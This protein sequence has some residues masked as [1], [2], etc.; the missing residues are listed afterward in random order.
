MA[1]AY[2][3][4]KFDTPY[5]YKSRRTREVMYSVTVEDFVKQDFSILE[6]WGKKNGVVIEKITNYSDK[7][8]K[9]AVISQSIE[10]KKTIK[11]GE[12][13]FL[14]RIPQICGTMPS[15]IH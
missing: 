3:T 14:F 2:M 15:Y 1:P 7:V 11:E 10:A 13:L 12:T 4:A 6:A 8:L 5:G 9:D